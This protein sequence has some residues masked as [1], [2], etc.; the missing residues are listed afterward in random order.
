M[1]E[2][3]DAIRKEIDKGLIPTG[4]KVGDTFPVSTGDHIR[5]TGVLGNNRV[6]YTLVDGP[7]IAKK[8]EKKIEKKVEAQKLPS[9]TL[10]TSNINLS[11]SG[12][13]GIDVA[14]LDNPDIKVNVN[15]EAKKGKTKDPDPYNWYIK[16]RLKY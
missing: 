8:V 16:K 2:L 15:A 9:N 5:I 14:I 6:N 11:T 13:S 1:V 10:T 7:I 12:T 3:T 4:A